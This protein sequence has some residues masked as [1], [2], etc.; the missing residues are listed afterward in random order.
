MKIE[1]IINFLNL[2]RKKCQYGDNLHINGIVF[3]HGR[4]NGVKIGNN[5]TIQ[6]SESI[7][8][9][10]GFAHTHLRA[11]QDGMICIGNNVGISHANITAFSGVTIEDNVLIGSGAKIW[12]TDFHPVNYQNRVENSEPL[13][14][15]IRIKEGA[16]VGACSIILKGVTIGEH[17]VIG[18][19]SVVTKDV[20]D[21]EVWARNPAKLMRKIG[22]GVSSNLLIRWSVA[23]RSLCYA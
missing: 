2:R 1:K 6:S 19:G 5:C 16:F 4:K 22:G 21:N 7:N 15:P 10:S 23:E 17:S 11:E 3:I 8:P 20:P 13:S 12:D 18:A 9:T 14:R